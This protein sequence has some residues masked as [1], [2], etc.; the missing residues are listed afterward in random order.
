MSQADIDQLT[1]LFNQ[2]NIDLENNQDLDQ[3]T[4]LLSESHLDPFYDQ[5]NDLTDSLSRLTVRDHQLVA[6]SKNGVR[7]VLFSW[8]GGCRSELHESIFP[9]Y[10]DAC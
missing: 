6:E 8:T 7:I 10:I 2:L 4:D 9:P 1:H 3:L 5:L